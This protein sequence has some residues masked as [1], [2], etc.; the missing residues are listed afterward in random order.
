MSHA[1]PA[2]REPGSLDMLESG[3]PLGPGWKGSSAWARPVLAAQ[4]R[5]HNPGNNQTRWTCMRWA[6]LGRMRATKRALGCMIDELAS[7]HVDIKD[8]T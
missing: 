1:N 4:S 6:W 8:E 5:Q 3:V 7:K 2:R